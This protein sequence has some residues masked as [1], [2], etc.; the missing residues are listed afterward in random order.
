MT[1]AS[2]KSTSAACSRGRRLPAQLL[3]SSGLF[4]AEGSPRSLSE[5]LLSHGVSER[6]LSYRWAFQ[7]LAPAPPSVLHRVRIPPA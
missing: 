1:P 4:S 6:S 2:Q 5:A 7:A 3:G